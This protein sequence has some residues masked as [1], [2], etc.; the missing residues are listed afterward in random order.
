MHTYNMSFWALHKIIL[1]PCTPADGE[2]NQKRKTLYIRVHIA[3]DG[4]GNFSPS[5]EN[6]FEE[7]NF[8]IIW[9]IFWVF[10]VFFQKGLL[11]FFL[12]PTLNFTWVHSGSKMGLL[13]VS[14]YWKYACVFFFGWGG[15][16]SSTVFTSKLSYIHTCVNTY[17]MG[18][19]TC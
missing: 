18:R 14:Y 19:F 5:L 7:K 11:N 15:V 16:L 12:N 2:I 9:Y 8:F 10:L 17:R 6:K 4:L 13:K 1:F 3:W